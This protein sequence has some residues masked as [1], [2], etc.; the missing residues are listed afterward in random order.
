MNPSNQRGWLAKSDLHVLVPEDGE[1][2]IAR[3]HDVLSRCHD[4]RS[5]E[6]AVPVRAKLFYGNDR[7]QLH[8]TQQ[9]LTYR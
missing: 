6:H 9:R 2:D 7:S 5:T 8:S 1:L 4:V 3:F